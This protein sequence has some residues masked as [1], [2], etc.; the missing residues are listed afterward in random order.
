[1]EHVR[2]TKEPRQ[3]IPTFSETVALLM[4]P[5]NKHVK[6]N[7]DV[8]VFSEPVRLFTLMHK[9][10]ASVEGWQETLAPRILLG[11][12][13]PKFIG[14]ARDI[15][16]YCK[17]SHI[18]AN[19]A[20]ARKYFWDSVDSFSMWFPSMTTAEGA[21]FRQDCKAAGKRVMV[22]TVNDEPEMMEAARMGVDVIL[23]DVPRTWLRLRAELE[24][25]YARVDRTHSRLFMWSSL[26][27]YTAYHM[28][29]S[30]H[31]ERK[32]QSVG[33]AFEAGSAIKVA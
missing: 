13:H 15:L 22:W 28:A 10:I 18:G 31:I 20:I 16:P 5:E 17:R 27:F 7:V 11:L 14:P 30:W 1:M 2:T 21:R 23:T 3:S 26:K 33:G 9:T 6:F 29:L 19:V 25:D 12:W 24:A 8:K 4:R 32:L